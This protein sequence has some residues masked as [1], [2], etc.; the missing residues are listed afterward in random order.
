MSSTDILLA[1]IEAFIVRTGMTPTEFGVQ[2]LRDP[3]FMIR[4]RAGSD[5]RLR[6]ADKVRAFMASH[7]RG[8]QKKANHNRSVAA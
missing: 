3:A 1:E 8:R 7:G 6:T 5:V 4:L 2:A